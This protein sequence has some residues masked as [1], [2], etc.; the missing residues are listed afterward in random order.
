MGKPIFFHLTQLSQVLLVEV[1]FEELPVLMLDPVAAA[2]AAVEN[3][4][5]ENAELLVFEGGE[6]VVAFA[7]VGGG[8]VAAGV[9]GAAVEEDFS[10]VV[11]SSQLCQLCGERSKTCLLSESSILH[12]VPAAVFPLRLFPQS[13]LKTRNLSYFLFNCEF[14]LCVI[15]T[16]LKGRGGRPCQGPEKT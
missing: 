9:V 11:A 10:V 1:T 14:P 2:E 16:I 6:A 8:E 3:E 4:E 5:E 12:L 13:S 15:Y 7:V